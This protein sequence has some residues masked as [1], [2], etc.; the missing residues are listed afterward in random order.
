LKALNSG[1]LEGGQSTSVKK[2]HPS[3]TRNLILNDTDALLKKPKSSSTV[4]ATEKKLTELQGGVELNKDQDRSKEPK[5]AA[6]TTVDDSEDA[7]ATD[8]SEEGDID[9]QTEALLKCFESD[10]DEAKDPEDQGYEAGED[11]P[12]IS[13]KTR[14]KAKAAEKDSASGKPGVVYVGR[15]PHGFYEQEMKQYFSQFGNITN[16]RLSRNRKTGKSK[17]FAFVEFESAEVAEIVS[18]TMDNYLL[19]G[20]ILKCKLVAPEQVHKD[21]WIGANKRFKSVPWNKIQGRKLSQPMAVAGWESRKEKE[22]KRRADKKAAMKLIGY[23]FENPKLKSA[24]EVLKKSKQALIKTVGDEEEEEEEEEEEP[25][26]IEA[27]KGMENQAVVAKSKK[28]KQ[29][30]DISAA[31]K[32]SHSTDEVAGAIAAVTGE[33]GKKTKNKKEK[34]SDKLVIAD[35]FK[36]PVS[37]KDANAGPAEKVEKVKKSKKHRAT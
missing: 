8:D 3:E 33:P 2:S 5:V 4:K 19:F 32:P 23:D 9:D 37:A 24:K 18:K 12:E 31:D 7:F 27:P 11:I 28:N 26:A 29:E 17:H 16:L 34:F 21:L 1:P 36:K 22:E 15:I 30:K 6:G 25:K 10:D 14:K 13:K 35:D 20:H